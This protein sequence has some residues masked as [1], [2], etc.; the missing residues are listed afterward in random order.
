MLYKTLVL[1]SVVLF[2]NA[3]CPNGGTG[4]GETQFCTDVNPEVG[5]GKS[6][7]KVKLACRHYNMFFALVCSGFTFFIA[8]DGSCN[9]DATKVTDSLTNAAMCG[10]GYTEGASVCTFPDILFCT[11]ADACTLSPGWM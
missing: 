10:L 6:F 5:V 4:I 11:Y 1:S 8:K 2:A 3:G 9:E 7:V